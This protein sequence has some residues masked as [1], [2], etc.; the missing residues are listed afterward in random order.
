MA[1]NVYNGLA[2]DLETIPAGTELYRIIPTRASYPGNSYNPKPPR[3]LGHPEQGRFEPLDGSLGGYIYL[4][5]SV[6]GAIAEGVLRGEEI[7]SAVVRRHWLVGKSLVTMRLEEE[8]VVASL[9][10]AKTARLNLSATLLAGEDYNQTRE[11]GTKVLTNTPSASGLK[12]RCANHDDLTSL[13]FISR[14]GQASLT[15]LDQSDIFFD[16][17]GRK[18]V[19]DILDS[20]FNLK[21]TGRVGKP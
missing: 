3:P 13:M 14:H 6:E 19:L 12:Y 15:I 4:A 16:D 18:K 1:T 10:G 20:V 11:T 21:Y 7:R 9:Y 2:A 17:I 5:Q 8:V